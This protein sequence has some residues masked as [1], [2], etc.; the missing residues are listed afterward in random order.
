MSTA[1]AASTKV[2]ADKSSIVQFDVRGR[3]GVYSKITINTDSGKFV[4]DCHRF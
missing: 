3:N 2:Q 4:C 1:V